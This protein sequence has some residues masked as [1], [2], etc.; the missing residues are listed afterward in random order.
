MQ[1]LTFCAICLLAVAAGL[2][3]YEALN[4]WAG[5][6]ERGLMPAWARSDQAGGDASR[7]RAHAGMAR[8]WSRA[9]EAFAGFAPLS[10]RERERSRERLR[11]AGIALEPETWRCVCFAAVSG[12]VVIAVAACVALR[13]TP[14]VFAFVICGAGLAG[15]GGLQL[16]LR[17]KRQARRA[18]IDAGL[19]DAMELLGVA[20][21]AG[22]P[23]EQ[24]FRQVAE[25]LN[26]PLAD[27]FRLVD[28]E[29]NLLGHSRAKALSNLAQRCA[30]QEVTAFAAQLTQA[31]E[32]GASVAQGLANQAALARSR[33]Q[34]AALEHIR[35]MPT[36]LDVVLSV[37]FLPPTTLLV[38]VP[39]VVDLLAFL[40]G[41]LA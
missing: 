4:A 8:L 24:C 34:A 40:G 7:H 20:I 3:V 21:A 27:E 6:K 22:S 38:L 36:K 1:G 2:A 32:Q 28:Q 9:V 23:V 37:C 5:A 26:G 25:S 16:Y 19:P 14:A 17:S 30:S 29:V 12:C 11:C 41:G 10:M 15:C 31:I 39:T 33:A 13:A 35:K 18:A